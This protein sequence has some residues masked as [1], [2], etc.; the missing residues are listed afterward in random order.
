LEAENQALLA[1][2]TQLQ[3]SHQ[4]AGEKF[5]QYLSIE[6]EYQESQTRFKTVFEQSR[7]GNKIIA[8]DL[9]IIKV[10][11]ALATM[12]GYSAAE[13]E[14]T[15]ILEYARADYVKPWHELQENLWTKQ[16]PSF[17]MEVVLVKKDSSFLWCSVHSV[18][19]RD[20]GE[21]LGY[22]I[23][24]D[25]S[26]RKALEEK[27]KKVYQ[28]QETVMHTVAHDLKNPI[29][30]IKTLSGFLKKEQAGQPQVNASGQSLGH[31]TM[32]EEACEKAYEII[33]DLLLIG[34]IES[35]GYTFKKEMTDLKRFVESQVARFQVTS[36]QKGVALHLELPTG[37]V[38]VPINEDKLARVMDN[39]LSN[40]MKFTGEGGQVRVS[41][42]E[43]ARKV[44]LQVQDNGV[45]IPESLQESVFE[46]F[47]KAGRSGTGGE[48]TTGL[49]LFIVKQIVNLHGGRVW[50][51][52]IENESTTLLVELPKS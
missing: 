35:P 37:P 44:I 8:S 22:T 36:Q 16:I 6:K 5:A 4:A 23:L 19:F 27:L 40:A 24:E 17:G 30:I 38:C 41:L 45:G 50:L 1:Q 9:R 52:S 20:N 14:G 33:K 3:S 29:H 10:N 13:L 51:E 49:G 31:I 12:L 18:L 43:E 46:K 48:S 25:I 32:I 2:V 26:P 39:L 34:K 28:A 47:T 11:K 21:T 7:L 15:R 42:Q